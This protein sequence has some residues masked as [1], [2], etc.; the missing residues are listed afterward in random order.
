MAQVAATQA[1]PSA[2][3]LTLSHPAVQAQTHAHLQAQ[4]QVQWQTHAMAQAQVQAVAQAQ[5]ALHLVAQA[6]AQAQV[7]TQALAAVHAQAAAQTLRGGTSLTGLP[8]Q[9]QMQLPMG[10]QQSQQ[11]SLTLPV[12]HAVPISGGA[13][14]VAPLVQLHATS[15]FGNLPQAL[16]TGSATI[17]VLAAANTNLT[18]AAAILMPAA[19]GTT[20]R[21][22]ADSDDV[23]N[24]TWHS[25]P[26]GGT[27]SRMDSAT[28]SQRPRTCSGDPAAT[29]HGAHAERMLAATAH[30][31][32]SA[33]GMAPS[34]AGAVEAL[35][36][37]SNSGSSVGSS[38]NYLAQG[39]T[40]LEAQVNVAVNAAEVN[41]DGSMSHPL[42][43]VTL[44]NEM[45]ISDGLREQLTVE[46][47]GAL[48]SPQLL[49][50]SG[51][52]LTN[53]PRIG[54]SCPLPTGINDQMAFA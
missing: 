14:M 23:L 26:P 35:L 3:Q 19:A 47:A 9:L 53:L 21:L 31:S 16:P 1:G 52:S 33:Q 45:S 18:T 6:N 40:T 44:M 39:T 13:R 32:Q 28:T 22:T 51:S 8:T 17:P 36:E 43:D 49:V 7:P 2:G 34:S 41:P 54:L 38:G 29:S 50:A 12:I 42:L 27:W 37:L 30:L 48:C 24:Q 15:A 25:L 46:G 4:A 20:A 5:A 11:Q 10:Q